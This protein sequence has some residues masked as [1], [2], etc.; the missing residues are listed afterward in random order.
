MKPILLICLF[1]ALL[2]AADIPVRISSDSP[3][4]AKVF[5]LKLETEGAKH[6]IQFTR[7]NSTSAAQFHFVVSWLSG[8]PGF[9]VPMATVQIHGKDGAPLY[10]VTRRGFLT[11]GNAVGQCVNFIVDAL[12]QQIATPTAGQPSDVNPNHS[13]PSTAEI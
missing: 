13:L 7:T 1:G 5:E 2:Q 8:G 6:N 9:R 11:R 4:A 12:R 3:D 10:T